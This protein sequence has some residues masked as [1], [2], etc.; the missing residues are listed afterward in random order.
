MFYDLMIC[1]AE[2][3]FRELRKTM[4]LLLT[5]CYSIY[6]K[7]YTVLIKANDVYNRLSSTEYTE[8][9]KIQYK[10]L[11]AYSFGGC[12]ISQWM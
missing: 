8:V 9:L 6:N 3:S 1:Y 10:F 5:L 2:C 7:V 12:V 4:K 11:F